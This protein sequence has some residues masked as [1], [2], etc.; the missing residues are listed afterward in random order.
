MYIAISKL[1][2]ALGVALAPVFLSNNP[3]LRV[4]RH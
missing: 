4:A 1:G 2:D 3:M